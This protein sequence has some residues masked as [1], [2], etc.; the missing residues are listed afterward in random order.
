MEKNS[1][2]EFNNKE[3][4]SDVLNELLINGAHQL[5]HQT[6]EA[7]LSEYL[8]QHQR[9]T[10]DGR[11]AL[12]CNDY[13]PKREILT[14]IGPVSVRIPKVRSKDG[15]A[16]TFRSALVTS[17]RQ[18]NQITGSG[19]TLAVPERCFYRRD[20]RSTKSSGRP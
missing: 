2:L 10:D 13:L 9:L 7:E 12:V 20:G 11:V 17:L 14:G 8:S 4:V 15:D 3:S 18:K 16:L 5:I 19:I 1:I 6:V